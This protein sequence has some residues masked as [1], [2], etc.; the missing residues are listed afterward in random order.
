M[1]RNVRLQLILLSMLAGA[2]GS[3]TA[4]DGMVE[5]TP[6]WVQVAEQP[7]IVE[8]QA[9]EQPPGFTSIQDEV[10]SENSLPQPPVLEEHFELPKTETVPDVFE[11]A[12]SGRRY[13]DSGWYSTPEWGG[14]TWRPGSGGRLW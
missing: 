7:P 6:G 14:M 12:V 4:E 10:G 3:A 1:S 13:N 8:P 2:V 9:G 11:E 5:E